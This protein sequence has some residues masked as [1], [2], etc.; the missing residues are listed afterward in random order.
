ML[1]KKYGVTNKGKQRLCLITNAMCPVKEPYDNAQDN[2]V[3]IIS[4]QMK[5]HGMKLDCVII[6]GNQAEAGIHIMV[7][8]N[9]CLLQKF[10]MKTTT[11]IVHIGDPT[12][13]LGAIKTRRIAPVTIFRGD[14]EMSTTMKIKV[15]TICVICIFG[16]SIRLLVMT[17]G[18]FFF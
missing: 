18:L 6:K 16:S 5:G 14:L 2:Q 17:I 11:K 8:E 9:E 12:S 13:I 1:I 7:D 15:R 4:T 10:S 3:D